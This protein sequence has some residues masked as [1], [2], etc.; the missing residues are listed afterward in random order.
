MMAYPNTYKDDQRPKRGNWAPGRYLHKCACGV[1]YTGDKYASECA[2]CAYDRP[3]PPAHSAS[4]VDPHYLGDDTYMS[5]PGC[6]T[7]YFGDEPAPERADDNI[8]V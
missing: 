2:D 3:E 7:R 8:D 5:E 6:G 1:R 4:S